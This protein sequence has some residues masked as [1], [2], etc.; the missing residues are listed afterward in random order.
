MNN[1]QIEY[2]SNHYGIKLNNEMETLLSMYWI[3]TMHKNAVESKFII[4]LPKCTLK[5]LSEDMTAIFNLFSKKIEKYYSK[6]RIWPRVKIF[7]FIQNNKP[8]IDSTN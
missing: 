4:A 6:N 1:E 8:V 3:P 7:W 5:P 2:L